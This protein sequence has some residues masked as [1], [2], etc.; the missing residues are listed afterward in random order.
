[1]STVGNW[2]GPKIVK[3]GLVL[4]LDAGSPNSFFNKTSTT[5]RDISGY[6]NNTS[7]INGVSFNN[8][9]GGVLSFDGVNQY[10]QISNS[11]LFQ[12]NTNMSV[13]IWVNFSDNT[14]FKIH[15]FLSQGTQE[16]KNYFWLSWYNT[17]PTNKR[18]YWELGYD[19]SNFI[20]VIY[21]W[22]PIIDTWYNIVGTFEPNLAKLYINGLLVASGSTTATYVGANNNSIPF[23]IGSYR[24]NVGYFF[25]GKLNQPLFYRKT[26]SQSEVLQNYNVTRFRYL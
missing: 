12:N 23:S 19:T 5:W 11:P 26:L 3:D 2:Q 4:Y 13:S 25:N 8:I 21:N 17:S 22:T 7:L 20:N 24:G 1:M 6:G 18:I 9:N 16:S 14:T 10:S 15:S